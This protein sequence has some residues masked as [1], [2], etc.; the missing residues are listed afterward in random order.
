MP[1]HSHLNWFQVVQLQEKVFGI[2]EPHHFEEVNSYLLLGDERCVLIDT[3]MGLFDIRAA[4]QMITPMEPVVINTHTDF[5]HI[6]ENYA[7]SEV[8]VFDHVLSRRRALEG[9]SVEEL[10]MESTPEKFGGTVPEGVR[11][12][13][14][15]AP[16]PHAQ[17]V[18]DGW[19]LVCPPFEL[20][21]IATPGHTQDSIC[22]Y[23]VSN[24]WLFAGD[25]LYAGPIFIEQDGGLKEY[26]QSLQ[27]LM[28]LPTINRIYPSHNTFDFP[29]SLL[30]RMRIESRTWTEN[31]LEKGLSVEGRVSVH[32]VDRML[33]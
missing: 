13:Y 30:E 18:P 31:Y 17:F 24:G 3:G 32:G 7:F 23:E 1:D 16:F 22:L 9:V 10:A 27:R 2:A 20:I 26:Q 4:V 21:V 33:L 12:P 15:I 11:L 28:D 14:A 8:Y 19:K 5:D 25:T 29:V 6:G